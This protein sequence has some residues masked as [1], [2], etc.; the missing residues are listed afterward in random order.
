MIKLLDRFASA[1]SRETAQRVVDHAFKHPM[2][3]VCLDAGALLIVR[4]AHDYLKG[5]AGYLM[6]RRLPE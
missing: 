5:Q 1:P 6:V 3:T 4:I 2:A